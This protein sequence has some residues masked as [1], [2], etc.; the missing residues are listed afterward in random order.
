MLYPLLRAL[1]FTLPAESAHELTFSVGEQLQK[2]SL[3]L[4]GLASRLQISDPRLETSLAGITFQ[5]PIGTAA[6]FDKNARV[7]PMLAACG[8]GFAEVGSVTGRAS[9]GNE[10]PRLFRLPQDRALI[11]RMGLNNHGPEE[12]GARLARSS[13]PSEFITGVNIAKTH[14][15]AIVGSAAV[16]DMAH[17]F[18]VMYDAA[19]FLVINVSCPNTSD[20]KTFETGPGLAELLERLLAIRS[21]RPV[22]KPIFVKFSPDLPDAELDGSLQV[23][24]DLKIDGYVLTNTTNSRAGLLTPQPQLD[25]IGRGGLS[26]SP[27][28]KLALPRVARVYRAL[29][30]KKPIIGVGGISTPDDA[31]RFFQAGASAIE[32]YTG[33]VYEGPSIAAKIMRGVLARLD[34]EGISRLSDVIG[35]AA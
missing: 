8:F 27:L 10:K 1:L 11:N 7:L 17:A 28:I 30:G 29:G 23:C 2:S 21:T 6:G 25:E 32:V 9:R 12:I 3:A 19:K 15:S 18:S 35:T 34:S 20:G 5:T 33:L 26:G 13:L 14:D 16:E 31:Y 22:R 24:E 4:R